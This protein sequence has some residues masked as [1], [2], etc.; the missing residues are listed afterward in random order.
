[1][2]AENRKP[3]NLAVGEFLKVIYVASQYRIIPAE[4]HKYLGLFLRNN[5]GDD[6]SVGQNTV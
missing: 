2:E 3:F 5:Y 6:G 4:N 1:M